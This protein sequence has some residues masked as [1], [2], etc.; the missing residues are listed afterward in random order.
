MKKLLDKKIAFLATDGF[1]QVELTQ[2]WEA[3]ENEGAEI[4]LVSLE[5]GKF[6]ALTTPIR[7]TNSTLISLLPMY[8]LP[9]TMVWCCRAACITQM[10]CA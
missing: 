1:E 2:P 5:E 7:A 3:I 9:I 4:H 8:R 10:P 6:K